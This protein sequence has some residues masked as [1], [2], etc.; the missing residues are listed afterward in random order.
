M[1]VEIE[2]WLMTK[3]LA[4]VQKDNINPKFTPRQYLGKY[5]FSNLHEVFFCEFSHMLKEWL[6]RLKDNHPANKI[7]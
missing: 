7:R 6:L 1:K 5:M 2:R 4:F 3:E